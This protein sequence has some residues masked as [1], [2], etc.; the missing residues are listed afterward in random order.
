[1]DQQFEKWKKATLLWVALFSIGLFCLVIVLLLFS[2]LLH[3]QE[4][5]VQRFNS[6]LDVE[7]V[8][9]VLS[10]LFDR[11]IFFV[12]EGEVKLLLNDGIPDIKDVRLQKEYPSK[13]SVAIEL[14][15]IVARLTIVNPD[16]D[17]EELTSTGAIADY[18]TDHGIYVHAITQ[19]G[20]R[21]PMIRLVD[22]GVRP[23][24][25]EAIVSP[26]MLMQM[27]ETETELRKQFGH[28]I[29]I[30]SIYQRGREYHLFV[31]GISLWFDMRSSVEQHLR[32]YRIFLQNVPREEVKQY[33]DLR[34]TDRVIHR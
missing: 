34:L 31:D 30:R 14:H 17:E 33:I 11:H 32:R 2:S 23:M 16:E 21:Y 3:I 6:R 9:R 24:P 18:V 26:E 7:K 1:M 12:Q 10:P 22:W 27:Q 13:L 29:S 20:E 4:I 15:P 28:E 25:G 5:N 8:Q 19:E